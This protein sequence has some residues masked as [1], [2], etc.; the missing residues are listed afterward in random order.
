MAKSNS[1]FAPFP[2]EVK[3]ATMVDDYRLMEYTEQWMH[4]LEEEI[5]LL[6]TEYPKIIEKFEDYGGK[7]II[8]TEPFVK[9]ILELGSVCLTV[10]LDENLELYSS[11][12][13]TLHGKKSLV[14]PHTS[15]DNVIFEA[16]RALIFRDAPEG[17]LRTISMAT[18]DVRNS[19]MVNGL[20]YIGYRIKHDTI[21]TNNALA[22]TRIER[23]TNG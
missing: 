3:S 6:K 16:F 21:L 17:A 23:V 4:D 19:Q 7:W 2:A 9:A 10:Q 20:G 1:A 14:P 5:E 15:E 8:H 18:G 22:G 11:N 12:V 13:F